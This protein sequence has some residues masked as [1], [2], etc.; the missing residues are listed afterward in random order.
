M[1]DTN[2]IYTNPQKTRFLCDCPCASEEL[3]KY[4]QASFLASVREKYFV[5]DLYVKNSTLILDTPDYGVTQKLAL[6]LN[7]AIK[8]MH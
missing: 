2:K 4:I 6:L 1:F 5:A 3:A 7:D 8:N